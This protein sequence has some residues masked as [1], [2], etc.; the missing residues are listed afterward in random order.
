[1]LLLLIG[2]DPLSKSK[3]E[4]Y[5]STDSINLSEESMNSITLNSTTNDVTGVLGKPI[6][7]GEYCNK[8]N[9]KI[10]NL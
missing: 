2:C 8:P 7:V 10:S 9:I 6:K 3:M 5:N 4:F 1:M